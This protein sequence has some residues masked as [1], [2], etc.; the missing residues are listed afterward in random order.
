M[1]PRKT[2]LYIYSPASGI[3]YRDIEGEILLLLPDDPDLYTFNASAAFIWKGLVRRRSLR[4]IIDELADEFR[5]DRTQA[6]ADA[7]AFVREME[8]KGLLARKKTRR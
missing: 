3:A 7:T 6:E 4:R 8:E 5:I 2:A 1:K